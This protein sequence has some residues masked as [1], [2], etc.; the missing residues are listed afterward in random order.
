MIFI[1][2]EV[3]MNLGKSVWSDKRL[4]LEENNIIKSVESIRWSSVWDLT[5]NYIWACIKFYIIE[6]IMNSIAYL[7][8]LH[9]QL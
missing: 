8:Y 9:K 1:H 2:M 5:Y 7:I 4:A 6:P 3:E